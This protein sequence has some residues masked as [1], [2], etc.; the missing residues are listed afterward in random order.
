[1]GKVKEQSCRSTVC[2][3]VAAHQGPSKQSVWN[4]NLELG[5]QILHNIFFPP[6]SRVQLGS[7]VGITLTGGWECLKPCYPNVWIVGGFFW[8]SFRLSLACFTKY[9]N[10]TQAPSNARLAKRRQ[11]C[12]WAERGDSYKY[13]RKLRFLPT[14]GV[15]CS[16][17]A[18]SRQTPLLNCVSAEGLSQ[19][20]LC[21]IY[22]F[23][24][25]ALKNSNLYF[26]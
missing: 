10:Y 19:D 3:G 1:M 17:P 11:V 15:G 23:R 7:Y 25:S 22:L 8:F 14:C 16:L 21:S 13:Q 24:E 12:C 26:C 20:V 4:G 9:I 6:P 2:V 18:W 5:S